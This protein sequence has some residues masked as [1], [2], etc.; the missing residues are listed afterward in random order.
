MP[1]T[2]AINPHDRDEMLAR[3]RDGRKPKPLPSQEELDRAAAK[4]ADRLAAKMEEL[5]AR[6]PVTAFIDEKR[7]KVDELETMARELLEVHPA[8]KAAPDKGSID[9]KVEADWRELAH[10]SRQ[11][12]PLL[13]A[14]ELAN[15]GEPGFEIYKEGFDLRLM[16]AVTAVGELCS[17]L[18]LHTIRQREAARKE[19]PKAKSQITAVIEN[20]L[21]RNPNATA[22]EI[23]T[24]LV[25]SEDFELSSDGLTILTV[26]KPHS[27]LK[28][29]GIPAAVSKARRK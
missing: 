26:N 25:S 28:I 7:A 24:A 6:V 13:T 29:S 18:R 21:K 20:Q 23:E 12:R 16:Q 4:H 14:L 1:V 5:R 10:A 15:A 8:P 27:H 9:D 19:R 2:D 11:L 3:R 17:F 22:K